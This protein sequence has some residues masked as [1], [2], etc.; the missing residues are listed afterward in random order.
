MSFLSNLFGF[1]RD[2]TDEE[3]EDL[4]ELE[5]DEDEDDDDEDSSLGSY[6]LFDGMSLD[7]IRDG[8]LVLSGKLTSH[9][10]DTLTLERLPGWL[11]FEVMPEGEEV[12]VRGYNSRMEQFNMTAKIQDSSRVLC[13]LTDLQASTVENQRLS[14][15]IPTNTPA[16]LYRREDEKCLRAENCTLVDVSTGGCCIESDYVHEEEEVLRIKI[17]LEDYQPMLLLGQIIRAST[18]NGGQYRYGIL[19]AQ[20]RE[21]E[22]TSLT[23]TLYNIQVGNRREWTRSE[24]GY[25][26]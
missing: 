11:S 1:V 4:E 25:W 24:E 22:L 18:H 5:D 3:D 16:W 10:A 13:K 6:R 2:D 12:S 9:T 8:R 17:K 7:V 21:D 15:R 14:F 23:R 19:F 26:H 20:P